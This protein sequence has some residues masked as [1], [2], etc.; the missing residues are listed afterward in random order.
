MNGHE[1]IR[2]LLDDPCLYVDDLKGLLH[3]VAMMWQYSTTIIENE[4]LKHEVVL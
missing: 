1:G 2:D 4:V 3:D